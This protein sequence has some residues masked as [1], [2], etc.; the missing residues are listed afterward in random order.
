MFDARIN[1][2]NR[3]LEFGTTLL[4]CKICEILQ[5]GAGSVAPFCNMEKSGFDLLTDLAIVDWVTELN[6]EMAETHFTSIQYLGGWTLKDPV[7][8]LICRFDQLTKWS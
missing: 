8:I 1:K 7:R 4:V 2:I 3:C 6:R 5:Q